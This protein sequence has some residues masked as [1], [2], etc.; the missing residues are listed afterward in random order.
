MKNVL[1]PLLPEYAILI[2]Q[3]PLS[4]IMW[5][6]WLGVLIFLAIKLREPWE[7]IGRQKLIWMSLLSVLIL[8]FTPFLGINL[9]S[10]GS[11]SASYPP[12]SHMMFFAAV[13]WMLA[14]GMIGLL[15]AVG[16]AGMSGLLLAYLDTHN[17]FTPLLFMSIALAYSWGI[18][19][20]YRTHFFKLL[21]FPVFGG[22]VSMVVCIGLLFLASLLSVPGDLIIKIVVSAARMPKMIFSLMGMVFIG[23]IIA[24]FIGVLFEKLWGGEGPLETA[25]GE[26]SLAF[27]ILVIIIPLFALIWCGLAIGYWRVT[28]SDTRQEMI[29]QL[30]NSTGSVTRGASTF[31]E[32]GESL[33]NEI[34]IAPQT[35]TASAV[36]LQEIFAQETTAAT[37]FDQLGLFDKDGVLITRFSKDPPET[38]APVPNGLIV[39]DLLLADGISME[40]VLSVTDEELPRLEFLYGINDISGQITRIVWG[41]TTVKNNPVNQGWITVISNLEEVGGSVQVANAFG[42]IL[43]QSDSELVQEQ[44]QMSQSKTPTF[45]EGHNQVGAQTLNYYE[46]FL[47][48][49]WSV[50]ASIPTII[51]QEITWEKTKPVLI[52]TI[53][54]MLLILLV[55]MSAFGPLIKDI[56]QINSLTSQVSTGNYAVQLERSKAGAEMGQLMG[57]VGRMVASLRH[58]LIHQEKLLHTSIDLETQGN[59]GGVI[60]KIMQTALT[61]KV[62]AVR[63][64]LQDPL[65]LSSKGQLVNQF[66]LGKYANEFSSI[67][68]DILIKLNTDE[69]MILFK[70]QVGQE[71]SFSK[72]VPQPTTVIAHSL[73]WEGKIFGALWVTRHDGKYPDK[74]EVSFFENLTKIA[75][76]AVMKA[77]IEQ[78]IRLQQTQ[79]KLILDAVPDAV[80]IS[81]QSGQVIYNNKRANT[82][83]GHSIGGKQLKALFEDQNL[84]EL[85]EWGREGFHSKE[86]ETHEGKFFHVVTQPIELNPREKGQ[87]TLITELTDQ[88]VRESRK[89]EFVTTVSHELRSP[90]TLIHGY[91]KIL[92]LTGDLNQQQDGYINKIIGSVEEMTNLVQNLLDLGRL[93]SGTS[94]VLDQLTVQEIGQK[95]VS[96]MDVQAKQKN[97]SIHTSFPDTPIVFHGD[98]T[99]LTQ[100]LRNLLDNAIKYTKMG[101]KVIMSA[102]T[103]Q[104]NLTFSIKDTGIGIAPLDQRHIFEKFKSISKDPGSEKQGSGLGLAI[105]KSIAER[106]QGRVWFET[107][108]GQGSTFYFQIPIK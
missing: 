106:H 65:D 45:F 44:Y 100:A 31:V 52:V 41:Q 56:K 13:P 79:L 73:R 108:L 18:R 48:S 53:V 43:Y 99:L 71:L 19:Q 11:I 9:G 60:Q 86:I 94:L 81:D 92:R 12:I 57:V 16:L 33:L 2:P 51:I 88:R 5:A 8:I 46:P 104:G 61:Q 14:G 93:E 96:N 42:E 30:I 62:T 102:E 3:E 87:A 70:T 40:I 21:R 1:V 103:N 85:L 4:L 17:I 67:D 66:G 107:K 22:L 64:A 77:Q 69:N 84:V 89:S 35:T 28:E 68:E 63:V 7:Q 37:F 6:I 72:G 76:G 74:S 59:L 15:P 105:V 49:D 34:A 20:R 23:G 39:K 91:A 101:G 54:A 78:N 27:R 10:E 36:E 98:S 32:T 55:A 97:I 90:L 26:K 80:L 47:N 83:L 75:S 50:L 25:P 58:Q 82:L 29:S 38:L 24:T 95:I